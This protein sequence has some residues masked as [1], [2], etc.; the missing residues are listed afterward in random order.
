MKRDPTRRERP[1]SLHE[2]LF[3][4]VALPDTVIGLAEQS[5]QLMKEWE[6]VQDDIL[7]PTGVILVVLQGQ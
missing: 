7:V 3:L 2:Q 6:R 1:A 5:Q 4:W